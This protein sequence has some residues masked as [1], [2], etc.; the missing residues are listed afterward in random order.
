ML[1]ESLLKARLYITGNVPILPIFDNPLENSTND[2]YIDLPSA[3][4]LGKSSVNTTAVSVLDSIFTR[5]PTYFA[6]MYNYHRYMITA[7]LALHQEI[8]ISATH[9]LYR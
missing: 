4:N 7:Y 9:H 3:V 5:C 1:N 2:N 6:L 8:S